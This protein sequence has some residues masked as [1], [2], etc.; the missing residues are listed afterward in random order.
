MPSW[1]RQHRA[2]VYTT[3]ASRMVDRAFTVVCWI[4]LLHSIPRSGQFHMAQYLTMTGLV[5]METTHICLSFY[6]FLT[7][8]LISPPHVEDVD[9]LGDRFNHAQLQKFKQALEFTGMALFILPLTRYLGLLFALVAVPLEYELVREETRKRVFYYVEASK[10]FDHKKLKSWMQMKSLAS[11]LIVGVPRRDAM[12][13]VMSACASNVVDEVVVKA[14]TKVDLLFIEKQEIDFVLID[15][16][17]QTN[18]VTDEVINA[19]R[20]LFLNDHGHLR[21]VRPKSAEYKE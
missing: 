16:P 6:K 3:W 10:S 1:P 21:R 13:M 17:G 20:V 4:S 14:P 11:K 18:L 15:A 5:V 8:H 19:N 7:T 9:I 12:D 2:R